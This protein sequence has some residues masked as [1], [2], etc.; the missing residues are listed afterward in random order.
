MP[1]SGG[2]TTRV[3]G[4][5]AR[6][7]WGKGNGRYNHGG[8]TC[9]VHRRWLPPYVHCVRGRRPPPPRWPP[10]PRSRHTRGGCK[11]ERGP[12][13]MADQD[14]PR[15]VA[16]ARPTRAGGARTPRLCARETVAPLLTCACKASS[17]PAAAAA[18]SALLF[19]PV[20]VPEETRECERER[21]GEMRGEGKEGADDQTP[22]WATVLVLAAFT[23]S[24]PAFTPL[25][26]RLFR[27]CLFP[28]TIRTSC[29]YSPALPLLFRP[30]RGIPVITTRTGIVR[31][32]EPPHPRP[33]PGPCAWSYRRTGFANGSLQF[34]R[35][36]GCER[37]HDPM[38]AAFIL[39]D[40]PATTGGRHCA[41]ALLA[42]PDASFVC[43]RVP[44]RVLCSVPLPGGLWSPTSASIELSELDIYFEGRPNTCRPCSPPLSPRAARSQWSRGRPTRAFSTCCSATTDRGRP[45]R[46]SP[47]P[48]FCV[49]LWAT[50]SA[51]QPAVARGQPQ[52]CW[53]SSEEGV[54]VWWWGGSAR[55]RER[56]SARGREA[57]RHTHTCTPTHPRP[58]RE[59]RARERERGR[60]TERDSAEATAL[61]T[62]SVRRAAEAAKE[63]GREQDRALS[64]FVC[65]CVRARALGAPPATQA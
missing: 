55:E 3:E 41:R 62:Q 31:M 40:G 46:R 27:A 47:W 59:S 28:M 10:A 57:G 60:D 17:C 24:I 23:R 38:R 63:N 58:H 44:G 26:L 11:R 30:T 61:S 13:T 14:G 53:Q 15:H 29:A 25:P 21:G 16:A 35:R 22:G 33:G 4:R 5:L 2:G 1:E 45:S 8:R 19:S 7:Q 32:R 50:V 36:P 43:Q 64:R 51:R 18:D 9:R 6:G 54:C 65:V 39:C 37:D 48:T 49:R 56:E 52:V 20:G 12:H 42:Q 34:Q